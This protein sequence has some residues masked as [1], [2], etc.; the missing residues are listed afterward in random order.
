MNYYLAYPVVM[1]V[2]AVVSVALAL[3]VWGRPKVLEARSL[4]YLFFA[5][6]VWT[7]FYGMELFSPD[8][9]AKMIFV[10]LQFLGIASAPTIFL[11]FT[12]QYTGRQRFLTRRNLL[13]LV[14]EPV[15][16]ILLAFTNESHRL[17]YSANVLET[18][19]G[20]PL[21]FSSWGPAGWFNI[22]Y[23]YLQ[24]LVVMVMLVQLLYRSWH[25]HPWKGL[26]VLAAAVAPWVANILYVFGLN[27]FR[28]LDL[29]GVSFIVVASALATGV[30]GLRLEDMLSVSRRSVIEQMKDGIVVLDCSGRI[31]DLNPAA[32]ALCG[33][34]AHEITGKPVSQLFPEWPDFSPDDQERDDSA[35]REMRLTKDS[36]LT[37][38][39]RL[40]PVTDWRG[41]LVS[42]VAT[43]RDISQRK[44]REDDLARR[45][46]VSRATADR[47]GLTGLLNHR[48]VRQRLEAEVALSRHTGH[49]FSIVMMDMDGFKRINDEHGHRLGDQALE[50]VGGIL[51]EATRKTDVVARYGGD[52]FLAV[53]LETRAEGA[54]II[55]RRWAR[56]I[57]EHSQQAPDGS[58]IHLG[59]SF[60]TASF[61]EDGVDPEQLIDTADGRLYQQK[62]AGDVRPS[63]ADGDHP[64]TLQSVPA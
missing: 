17:I 28:G 43:I 63:R 46:E 30:S 35:T 56:A 3:Y 19:G 6:A 23:C 48:A 36:E 60:G 2:A 26:A 47:D 10:K 14:P 42:Q 20:W 18:A 7:V 40:S 52:E 4:G 62:R 38:D 55:A 24:I 57:A 37:F 31:L 9:E 64:P 33:R 25:T 39:V 44:R 45:Y 58:P 59:M 12:L 61:P 51:I 21:L 11:I 1:F 8:L 32:L 16:I 41:I 34:Q 49:P 13:L 29:T 15:I 27:P 54:A 5:S 22:V 50:Q 53:L